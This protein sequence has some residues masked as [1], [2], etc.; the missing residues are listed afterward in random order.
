LDP[1]NSGDSALLNEKYLEDFCAFSLFFFV[2]SLMDSD[3]GRGTV[4]GIDHAR[5]F[6]DFAE[7]FIPEGSF[8]A[9]PHP[10][11]VYLDRVSS[12]CASRRRKYGF[13]D[14]NVL[15]IGHSIGGCIV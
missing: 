1:V 9:S 6:L 2:V 11:P 7:N 5:D 3:G 10:L 8:V 14:R 15:G 12:D 4:D 13:H